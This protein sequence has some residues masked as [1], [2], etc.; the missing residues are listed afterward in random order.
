[1][2]ITLLPDLGDH[3]VP[4]LTVPTSADTFLGKC[5]T[6]LVI[7]LLRRQ[8]DSRLTRTAIALHTLVDCT[9]GLTFLSIASDPIL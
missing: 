7:D 3:V 6:L 8:D 9:C 1:M 2:L 4:S 5:S